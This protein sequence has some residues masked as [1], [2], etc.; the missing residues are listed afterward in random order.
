MNK[1]ANKKN[2]RNMNKQ[3]QNE[4]VFYCGSCWNELGAPPGLAGKIQECSSCGNETLVPT[5]SIYL[6]REIFLKYFKSI[7]DAFQANDGLEKFPFDIKIPSLKRSAELEMGLYLL[8][9]LDFII[10]NYQTDKNRCC[11][12]ALCIDAVIPEHNNHIYEIV[13][14]REKI[15]GKISREQKGK[16]WASHCKAWHFQ[17]LNYIHQSKDNYEEIDVEEDRIVLA[18]WSQSFIEELKLS[19]I[20]VGLMSRFDRIFHSIFSDSSDIT[21]LTTDEIMSRINKSI[22]EADESEVKE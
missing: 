19:A 11:I 10:S 1:W 5:E 20:E 8:F 3:N 13:E 18:R 14:H 7:Y 12:H 4:L 2:R 6:V 16:D 22:K 17:L 21:S 15:Y 9:R